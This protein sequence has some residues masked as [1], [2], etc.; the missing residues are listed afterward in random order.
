[1]VSDDMRDTLSEIADLLDAGQEL[2]FA[3]EVRDKL[4]GSEERLEQFLVSNELWGGSGSLADS[5][6]V[7]DPNHP[8]SPEK[9]KS[10]AKVFQRLMIK[11]GRAQIA[12]GQV[13]VRTLMWVEAFESWQ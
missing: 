4:N 12:A 11:L 13:N 9:R 2:S 5:A 10:S 7:F 1:M 8:D 6:F 3:I